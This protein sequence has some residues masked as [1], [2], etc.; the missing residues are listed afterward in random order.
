M[1]AKA[2]FR[3]YR[4]TEQRFLGSVRSVMINALTVFR[5]SPMKERVSY[6]TVLNKEIFLVYNR[7][8][9]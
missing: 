1:G 5:R 8:F 2:L 3:S 9:S 7:I 6:V 4:L